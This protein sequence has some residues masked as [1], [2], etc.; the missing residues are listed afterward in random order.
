MEAA[1]S[2]EKS[3]NT[4]KTTRRHNSQ[5][6]NMFIYARTTDLRL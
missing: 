6:H 3:V 4:Y 1:C 2:T 5:D